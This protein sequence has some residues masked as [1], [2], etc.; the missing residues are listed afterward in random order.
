VVA[1]KASD[2]ANSGA[3]MVRI[4]ETMGSGLEKRGPYYMLV[5]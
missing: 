2:S 3:S 4:E 1:S 5:K